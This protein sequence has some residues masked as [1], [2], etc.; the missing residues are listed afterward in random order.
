MTVIRNF[1][2]RVG[3]NKLQR[4]MRGWV[5]TEKNRGRQ[6]TYGDYKIIKNPDGFE[7]VLKVK[8]HRILKGVTDGLQCFP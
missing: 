8:S 4:E 5:Q 7:T 6:L 1:Q 2:L 3:D